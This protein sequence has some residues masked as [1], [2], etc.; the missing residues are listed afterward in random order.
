MPRELQVED[1]DSDVLRLGS[2]SKE[3]QPIGEWFWVCA[4]RISSVSAN[5]G[6][7]SN[8]TKPR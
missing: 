8:F 1:L 7:A 5:M 6:I 2:D 3:E 4:L